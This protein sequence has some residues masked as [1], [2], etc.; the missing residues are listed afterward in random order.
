M[1]R[2]ITLHRNAPAPLQRPGAGEPKSEQEA[3]VHSLNHPIAAI[4]TRVSTDSQEREGTSLVTQEEQC[5][6]YCQQRGYA[7]DEARVYHETFTGVELWD[8]PQLTRMREAIR[9]REVQV[10]VAYAIDRLAREPVHLGVVLSEADYAG[11]EVQFVSEP[12]DNSPE[13]QL[14]RFVRGYAAKVEH[15][16]I[17]ERSIRGKLAR[18]R[19]GKVHNSAA[20]LYGY[21]RDK[22]AGVRLIHEAEAAIV[23][24]VFEWAAEG[25]SLRG[26]VRRLRQ[27]GVPAPSV[28]KRQFRHPQRDYNWG[29]TQIHRLLNE[30]AYKGEAYAWRLRRPTHEEVQKERANGHTPPRIL[31]RPQE[32][33]IRLPENSTPAIVS[34]T[35]WDEAQR[36]LQ[37]NGAY[38]L[39][40]NVTGGRTVPS[41]S[42]LGNIL[43]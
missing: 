42:P 11:V 9:R 31:L 7:V 18:I 29:K 32:E 40:Q 35:L 43:I 39:T 3:R 26:I 17:R 12:L 19:S 36:K 28:G 1:S 30:P 4:Y 24:R 33:W 34:P 8:R 15:M 37:R 41:P 6:V 13:G 21:R 5:R 2:T 22:E 25:A 10:V 20:E 38:S 16:K 14:I 27:E 23:R